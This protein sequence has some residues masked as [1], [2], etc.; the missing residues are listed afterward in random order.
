VNDAANVLC[1]LFG[2]ENPDVLQ[3]ASVSDYCAV[4]E[5]L[6]PFIESILAAKQGLKASLNAEPVSE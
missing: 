1:E 2:A 5:N 6:D 3:G 4:K